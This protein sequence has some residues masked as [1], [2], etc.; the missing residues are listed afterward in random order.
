MSI[1]LILGDGLYNFLKILF[2]TIRSISIR[3]NNKE[4]KACK[5]PPDVHE[6]EVTFGLT[7]KLRVKS[8]LHVKFGFHMRVL[9]IT[10]LAFKSIR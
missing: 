8:H 6:R 2:F 5:S 7:V 9:L 4:P 1:A 10:Y 3:L